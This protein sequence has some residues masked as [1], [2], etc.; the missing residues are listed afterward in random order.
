MKTRFPLLPT[1]YVSIDFLNM[2]QQL[3]WGMICVHLDLLNCSVNTSTLLAYDHLKWVILL[4]ISN[5]FF[6]SQGKKEA[7]KIL[8]H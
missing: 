4:F 5:F 3:Q 8:S 6:F 1:I 7:W 2:E